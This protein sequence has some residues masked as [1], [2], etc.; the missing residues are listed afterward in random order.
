MLCR[1]RWTESFLSSTLDAM[2]DVLEVAR[3]WSYWD[4]APVLRVERDVTLPNELTDRLALVV[5]GVR[6]CGKSTLLA[7]MMQRYAL[8]R[9][10]CLFLNFEDPR[11]S[12]ALTH[13]TL[14]S[15]LVAFRKLRGVK[16]KLTFFLDEI[17]WVE[18][19]QKWLRTQLERPQNCS[20]VITGSNSNM[21]SGELGSTL[22][23]RHLSVELFPF[24]FAEAKR[25]ASRTSVQAYL[26]LGGFPEAI[27]S[28]DAPNLLRQYFHDIVERDVRERVAA[29][30]S[31][32]LRQLVQMVFES[33][34]S[35]LSV[36][37]IAGA[38][39]VAVDTAQGYLDACEAAYLLFSCPFF[40]FSERKRAAYN[41]KYYPIDT[42][43]R[44]MVVTRTGDDNGKHLE[45]ATLVALR[46]RYARVSYWRGKG[47][48]DFVVQDEAARPIPVQVSWDGIQERHHR[49]LEEFYETFPNA[50]EAMLV[51]QHSFAEL[52]GQ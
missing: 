6:R 52:L 38:A 11:L 41:R 12:N 30:S 34:G 37:R 39:G 46:R 24:S 44:K 31:L 3:D 36:R 29:R 16:A 15:A 22:T 18:G 43:L 42:A 27:Q 35:E 10:N 48:I 14:Q 5:K 40:A 32:A 50:G 19:W 28:K 8:R 17:Q 21:L 20:F 23:G 9:E 13:E 49:A 51:T 25:H 26:N 47:E 2:A 33:A 7:Q 1:I 45:C 4:V